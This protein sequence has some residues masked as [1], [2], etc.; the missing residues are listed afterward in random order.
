ME[1]KKKGLNLINPFPKKQRTIESYKPSKESKDS[2]F[3]L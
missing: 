1:H 3:S 2:I